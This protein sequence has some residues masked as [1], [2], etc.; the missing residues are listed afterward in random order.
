M[1]VDAPTN[2]EQPFDPY[3]TLR[4][5][6]LTPQRVREL[7]RLRPL[8]VAFDAARCWGMI[9]AAW[10]TVAFV[11]RWWVVLLA[12]PVVGTRF[13]ALWVIGHDG[14]HR[15]L[16]T[17]TQHNDLFSDLFVFGAIGAITR[18]NNRNHIDHHL[19]LSSALDPDRHK[20][21]SFN[22]RSPLELAAFLTGTSSLLR[23]VWNVF[24]P[25]KEQAPSGVKRRYTARDWT[26]LV[27]WQVLLI[28]GLTW[29]IGFWA[30]PVLWLLPVYVFTFLGDNARAFVEHSH[31]EV[32][33]LADRHRL[34]NVVSNPVE[35]L[36]FSPMNMNLHT[37]HHLWPSIPYYN[38]PIAN[39]ELQRLPA[40]QNID[41]RSSYLGYIWLYLRSTPLERRGSTSNTAS[42]T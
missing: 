21:G 14:L 39:E 37:A 42:S 24:G 25:K 31:P 23:S 19:H 11:H 28:T 18:L 17:K 3:V 20:H 22:K 36:F 13:Y 30:W 34:V 29:G 27:A 33:A 2:T 5:A 41:V 12:I 40:A 26:I 6:L 16:F 7:S 1:I 4:R 9:L 8:R 32:D 10:V 35:R 15:R 38:L